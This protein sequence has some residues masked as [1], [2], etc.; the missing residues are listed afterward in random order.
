MDKVHPKQHPK[1][2]LIDLSGLKSKNEVTEYFNKILEFGVHENGAL[3][4]V[5][6]WDAFNDC[7]NC[8]DEGGIYGTG[9]KITS[10]CQMVI[11]NYVDFKQNDPEGFKI[12]KEILE[13]KSPL[14]K[15]Y[16][17]ELKIIFDPTS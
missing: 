1:L 15:K 8:L 13:E 11:K 6:N 17:F 10:P 7:M 2:I 4:G 3:V 12:L 5:G 14:Y 9:Q 16:N